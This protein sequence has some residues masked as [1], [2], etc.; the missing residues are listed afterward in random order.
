VFV[1]RDGAVCQRDIVKI[2]DPNGDFWQH[3]YDGKG[4]PATHS[5]VPSCEHKTDRGVTLISYG[6]RCAECGRQ[7]LCRICDKP[8]PCAKHPLDNGAWEVINPKYEQAEYA[9]EETM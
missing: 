3:L 8:M 9:Q 6:G 5:A 4:S 1:Y 7:V 2:E